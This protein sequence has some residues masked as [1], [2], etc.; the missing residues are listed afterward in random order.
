MGKVLLLDCTL[1][2]GGYIND[3]NFGEETIKGFGRKLALTGVEI[4]EVGFIKGDI[5]DHNK[6]VFPDIQ[7]VAPIIQPKAAHM[8]YVGMIDMSAPIP[9]ERIVPYDG[10]SIDGIRVIFK[11]DKIEEAYRYCERI[12]ELGYFISVNVVGTDLYTDAEF[13]EVIQKFNVL[14][15]YAV[16]IVDTFGLIKRKHFLRLAYLADNNL[17]DGIMLAYHAHNNL[18]Q[19]YG[20]A[21]ALVDMSLKRDI[22]IDACVFGMGRGAGNL[23]LELFAEYMNENYDTHYKIEPML[24]IMDEYLN[25]IYRTKFW[26]YSLP[27]YLSAT[28]GSHPNYAIYLAEKNTL[29]VK[30]FNELLQSIPAEDKANFSKDKAEK[31]YRIYQENFVDDKEVIEELSDVLKGEKIVLLA[32]GKTLETH[33]TEIKGKTDGAIII[34]ANFTADK[35]G[36][37]YIFSSNMRRFIKIQGKTDAKCI[38]TSN[39]K[40][41]KQYDYM[42]NFSSY[43]SKNADIIDNSALMLLRMLTAVGVKEVE[44]A[45]MDGY[46]EASAV[47]YDSEWEYDFSKEAI[48]R[49]AAI[50]EEL[51]DISRY[52][53]IQFITP[54]VYTI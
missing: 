39:M 11:K 20:N 24:E 51:R 23:N 30:A 45:G 43:A 44:I 53:K 32:P 8:K 22:I 35:Y 38:I 26:G 19:A 18:Q 13:I 17:A 12:Q 4:F 9:L 6:S 36:P 25:E 33:S 14:R 48:Q 31:Y 16:S 46:S 52:L 41:A 54:T 3:W 29:T 1:R 50:S 10:T 49:N 21:E 7:S 37:D 2:D 40:E 42:L 5:Y 28:T 15:P 47:Y 27:L 34:A